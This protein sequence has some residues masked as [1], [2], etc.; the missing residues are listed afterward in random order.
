[1]THITFENY[2]IDHV[3]MK[4]N[5]HMNMIPKIYFIDILIN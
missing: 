1:M 4:N 3:E 2:V 5:F